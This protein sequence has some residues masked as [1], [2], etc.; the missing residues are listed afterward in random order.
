MSPLAATSTPSTSSVLEVASSTSDPSKYMAQAPLV[1][2]PREVGVKAN[3]SSSTPLTP[4]TVLLPVVETNSRPSGSRSSASMFSLTVS[5]SPTSPPSK[6]R[7]KLPAVL[8]PR[9]VGVCVSVVVGVFVGVFAGG[10]LGVS[11]AV[12]VVVCLGVVLT[13]GFVLGVGVEV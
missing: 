9:G 4:G 3:R 6:Y 5:S 11:V 13:V 2:S 12:A 7:L 1:V 8:P 10:G